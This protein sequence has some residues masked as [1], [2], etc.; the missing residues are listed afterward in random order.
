MAHWLVQSNPTK[1][2]VR[3]FFADGNQLES[4][5]ITRYRD[6]IQEGD[7]VALWLAGPDAGVVALG[8]VTGDVE[9]VPGDDDPYWTDR[10]DAEAVRMR[11]PLRLTEVF[12]DAPVTREELRHDQRFAGATILTQPFAGNPFLL[13]DEE[14]AAI[15]DHHRTSDRPPASSALDAHS[16]LASLVGQTIQTLSRAP[17]TV[18]RLQG[19]DV[20]VAT[21]RSPQGQ[22]VPIAWVQAALDRLRTDG[23]VEISVAS[24]GYRSAFVGAALAVLPGARTARNPQRV[25]LPASSDTRR[26]TPVDGVSSEVA[27]VEVAVRPRARGQRWS[28]SPAVRRAIEL[29]AMQTAIEHYTGQGWSV[30]DVSAFCSYDLHCERDDRVLHVEVKGTTSTGERVLLT[31]NEVAQAKAE[32]PSTALFVLADVTVVKEAD[33]GPS[34][35]GGRVVVLEPWMPRD[36]DL[37]PIAH[38]YTVPPS[39]SVGIGSSEDGRAT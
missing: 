20:I 17:N 9:D 35:H 3:E 16:H 34:A 13:T 6:Q 24:V 32:Y 33:D 31:R 28:E 12:L 1:W 11:M 7:D 38:E 37:E 21:T 30:E 29:H 22:P 27:A 8:V 15:L 39:G 23:E 5:S 14:W 19:D 25:L 2:R 18:L 36:E 26:R 10:A 4:W